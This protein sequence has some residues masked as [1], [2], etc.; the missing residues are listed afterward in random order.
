MTTAEKITAIKNLFES[1]EIKN[2]FGNLFPKENGIVTFNTFYDPINREEKYEDHDKCRTFYREILGGSAYKLYVDDV[3]LQV[4]W[5]DGCAHCTTHISLKY[6]KAFAFGESFALLEKEQEEAQKEKAKKV[7][8]SISVV[9]NLLALWGLEDVVSS[10]IARYLVETE[11]IISKSMAMLGA[12]KTGDGLTIVSY[13][14]FK[15]KTSYVGWDDPVYC[16]RPNPAEHSNKVTD[17]HNRITLIFDNDLRVIG[18]KWEEK[19]FRTTDTGVVS[20]HFSNKILEAKTADGKLLLNFADETEIEI[21]L[22][23]H[24]P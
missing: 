16:T 12:F 18:S 10:K 3:P 1:G 2:V 17:F 23:N 9:S 14:Y 24:Q 4:A 11:G 7:E 6:L 15:T 21:V 19:L 13:T 20:E 8:V 22:L 5:K